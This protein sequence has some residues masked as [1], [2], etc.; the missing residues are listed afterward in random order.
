[1]D[2]K[3]KWGVLGN[4]HIARV[5]VIPA[6]QKSSN[7]SVY[8]LATRSPETGVQVAAEH[9]IPRIYGTYDDLLADPEIQVIYNPLPNHLHHYWTLRALEAGKHVLCEKPLA[10]NARQAREMADSAKRRGLLLM[11]AFM[12]RFHPRS[13]RIKRLVA[14]GFIGLPVLMRTAFCY[15]MEETLLASGEC[16]R[17]KPQMGGGAL[18]DV[19]CY[20]VSVTRWLMGKEP[21]GL[22]GQAI[23]HPSGVDVHFVGS[24]RFPGK[25]LATL[26]ASFI[27]ALQQTYTILG[28]RSAI[29]L[30]HNAFIPWEA[31]AEF[32]LRGQ[33]AET[34]EKQVTAGA[35]EYQLMAEHF[36]DAVRG[37]IP[38]AFSPEESVRNMQVL[39]GLAE[40]AQTGQ[41]ILWDPSGPIGARP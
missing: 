37:R 22:Q 15:P 27:S 3:I 33:A 32:I 29:E 4:A 6:I 20:G 25:G 14:D 18:L 28:T 7:G 35:D 26:E 30:P 31:E 36:S 8:A 41:T 19:G 21:I 24:L 9:N 5:C 23:Y 40:A 39:D 38:L 34:G 11:E 17:L 16:S 10:C 2:K 1:M 12:Y 13:Q